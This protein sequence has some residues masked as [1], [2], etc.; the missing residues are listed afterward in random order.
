MTPL[1]R[2]AIG[3]LCA[4]LVAALG[5]LVLNTA[6]AAEL[7]WRAPE[8]RTDGTPLTNLAGY[9][10]FRGPSCDALAFVTTVEGATRYTDAAPAGTDCFGVTAVDADG[11][12]SAMVTAV[13]SLVARPAPVTDLVLAVTAADTAAY[14]LR[15]SVDG[16]ELVAFGTVPVG[17]RC[18]AA[19]TVGEFALIP[20]AA[21]TPRSRF[22]PLP[23]MAFAKC[24]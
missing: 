13:G 12:E 15:Q 11:L 1:T 5:A 2:R 24:S 3:V 6:H 4:L 16:F 22:E 17:T 23:L 8:L 7:T 20:R 14:K 21:V 19:R 10:V 18:N 9:R